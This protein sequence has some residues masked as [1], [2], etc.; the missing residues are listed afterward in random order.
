MHPEPEI[1]REVR[2]DAADGAAYDRAVGLRG[3]R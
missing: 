3:E 2:L 1:D